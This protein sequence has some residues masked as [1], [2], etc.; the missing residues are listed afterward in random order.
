MR[1]VPVVAA[2][3]D[4]LPEV[5]VDGVDGLCLPPE[6]PLSDFARYGGDRRDVYPLVFRPER[7][8]VGEP[9]FVDPEALAEAVMRLTGDATRYAAFSA[10]GCAAAHTRFDYGAH[11]MRLTRLLA[12]AGGA[13]A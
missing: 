9:G 2:C 4:G 11:L 5:I 13:R 8:T 3:V 10:S 12:G 1:G 6:R 7:D